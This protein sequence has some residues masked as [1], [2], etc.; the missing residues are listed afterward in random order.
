MTVEE[1]R[2]FRKYIRSEL[3]QVPVITFQSLTIS[4]VTTS[5]PQACNSQASLQT[6][7]SFATLFTYP[8]DMSLVLYSCLR[9]LRTIAG[10]QACKKGSAACI[11]R[12]RPGCSRC[13]QRDTSVCHHL[14]HHHGPQ[15]R[16]V[17]HPFSIR[18]GAMPSLQD[19]IFLPHVEM[20]AQRT[21]W[22]KLHFPVQLAWMLSIKYYCSMRGLNWD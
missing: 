2:Q 7:C 21:T 5:A 14:L 8:V 12:G 18:D 10:W 15:C 22:P 13:T 1:L 11:Q 6:S 4:D 16:Q 3:E 19:N 17:R 9:R 20:N